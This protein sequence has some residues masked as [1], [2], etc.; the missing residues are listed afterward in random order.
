MT[1]ALAI[2]SVTPPLEFSTE[3]R[4][5][6]IASFLSGASEPEAA[7]LMELARIRHLNPITRQI[8]FVK[9]W[10]TE[11]NCFVWASQVGIDGFRAIAERTGLYDGQDEAEFS[12]TP[13]GVLFSCK[14]RVYRKDWSRPAVGLAHFTEF[15]QYKKDGALTRMW[16]EKPHVMLAKCAEA[17][18]FRRGFPEDTSG[19][20]SP[21]EMPEVESQPTRGPVVER[22]VNAPP[23]PPALA[24]TTRTE[25]IAG[26]VAA[27]VAAQAPKDAPASPPSKRTPIQE[28]DA[29][30]K[31]KPTVSFG[32]TKG[33]VISDLTVGELS[34]AISLGEEKM[35]EAPS[36]TWAAPL[37]AC[38]ADLK[39]EYGE[40]VERAINAEAAEKARTRPV[41]AEQASNPV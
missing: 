37:A 40:R 2:R 28:C 16:K 38:M 10:D 24:P 13:E 3:Q 5:M 8:H 41:E 9:R 19:F 6:I 22:D 29:S 36:A 27:K 12:Y 34:S 30:G 11:K 7:V 31:P 20:Y 25:T 1:E 32:P 35:A 18:A 26:K 4:K 39:H 15:A 23:A 21:E 17:I 14:V 33:K